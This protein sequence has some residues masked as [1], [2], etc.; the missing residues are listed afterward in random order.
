MMFCI[1]VTQ[2]S[3][4]NWRGSVRTK[5][6]VDN[7]YTR[8]PHPFGELWGQFAYAAAD[9][10]GAV[11]FVGR[12]GAQP[13]GG[14]DG[15]LYQAFIDQGVSAL[16][17]RIKLG[18]FERTDHL[19]FYRVDGGSWSY[20]PRGAAWAVEA[21]AGRPGRIDHVRSV[22]GELVG[23]LEGRARLTLDWSAAD[24]WV[25]L[26]TLD[27]RGG[28]QH[29]EDHQRSEQ[30]HSTMPTVRTKAIQGEL[31][32]NDIGIQ[33]ALP[34]SS[35]RFRSQAS[36]V[37]R[38]LF[39]A[40]AAGRVR[41]W[42]KSEYQLGFLGTYR[43]DQWRFENLLLNGQLDFS[44]RLRW[45][46]SYEQYQPREPFLSFRE[47]F[48]S[49]YAL[50]QQTLF[51]TRLHYAWAEGVTGFIGGMKATREGSDGYGGDLGGNYAYTPNLI[52]SGELDYLS[53]GSENAKSLYAS[54]TETPNSRLQLRFN[55]A[56]RDEQKLLYGDNRAL[57]AEGELR[58]MI[59]NHLILNIAGSYI[60]NT[61]LPD[62][63]LGAVQFIYYF[64]PFKPKTM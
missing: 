62:E 59:H 3:D 29:F 49:T 52:F 44:R 60:W 21:Y 6:Q 40:N 51:R 10:R 35:L 28:Y 36:G 15:Q 12:L 64:D 34:D 56:L 47:K 48:Y 61:R 23:G 14:G 17:S 5:F 54:V 20:A 8:S 57:G 50:A 11:D 58:Y 63:Y 38:L 46:S 26:D 30:D 9:R 55:T 32:L 33:A 41:V 1:E 27:L 37:E 2:A 31:L 42:D 18:R 39:S 25:S 22:N 4:G 45:R 43:P 24:D 53:L 19:G 16:D 7:R 13:D